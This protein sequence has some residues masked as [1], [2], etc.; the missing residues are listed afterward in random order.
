MPYDRLL[1]HREKE[2]GIAF[3]V[4]F[5]VLNRQPVFVS[6]A[7]ATIVAA[8]VRRCD[9]L[10]ISRTH[11]WVVMPDHVHWLLSVEP[12]ISISRA[13]AGVKANSSRRLGE[14]G[15]VAP[16]QPGYYEHRVRTDDDLVAQA[17]Y[18]IANPLRAGLVARLSEYRWWYTRFA[19]SANGED[20]FW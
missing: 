14:A 3:N 15:F 19:C 9:Q 18:L 5:C 6:D 12:G 20:V 17:R 1:R 2:L 7:A 8:A 16:W 11:A 13:V 4:T 10:E